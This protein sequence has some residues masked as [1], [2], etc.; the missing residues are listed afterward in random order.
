MQ[1]ESRQA[2]SLPKLKEVSSNQEITRH[3]LEY[4]TKHSKSGGKHSR[5]DSLHSI[6][7]QSHKSSIIIPPSSSS[8]DES[9]EDSDHDNEAHD[10][11]QSHIEQEDKESPKAHRKISNVQRL[12]Q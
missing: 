8:I 12:Q 6:N 5:I 2:M 3:L 4:V 1:S 7:R 10:N 11:D 9:K